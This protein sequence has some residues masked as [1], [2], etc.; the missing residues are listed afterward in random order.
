MF[1]IFL[2]PTTWVSLFIL[3]VL[4][5]ILGIDNLVFISLLTHRLPARQQKT[6]W[7]VGLLL[8]CITRLLLLAAI[9]ELIHFT[10]PLFTLF[11]QQFSL[12]NLILI[13]GGLFLLVKSTSEIHVNVMSETVKTQLKRPAQFFIVILQIMILDI[14]FSLDSVFTAVGMVQEYLI[15]AIAIVVAIIIMLEASAPVSRVINNYP[16]IKMLALSFLLLIGVALLADGLG[17]HIPRGYLYFAISFSLFVEIL[18]IL[19]GRR[20]IRK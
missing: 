10:Q 17:F 4:E 20:R 18:N 2:N 5:I 8:A 14:I 9:T 3:I 19:A 15:M 12:Q 11:D 16:T 13:G 1:E 6:A 7:R